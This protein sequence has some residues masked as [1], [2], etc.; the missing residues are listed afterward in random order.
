MFSNCSSLNKFPDISKWNIV[1]QK[2]Y[3]ININNMPFL[4]LH[5]SFIQIIIKNVEIKKAIGMNEMLSNY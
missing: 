5:C 2:I 1:K 4:F 3:V